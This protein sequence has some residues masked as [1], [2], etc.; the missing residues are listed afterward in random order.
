MI[1]NNGVNF[2]Q[3]FVAIDFIVH[4]FQILKH[5]RLHL[6]SPKFLSGIVSKNEMVKNDKECLKLVDEAIN[7]RLAPHQRSSPTQYSNPR[8]YGQVLYAGEQYIFLVAQ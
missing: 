3:W 8:K 1:N 2:Y 7:Y 4:L 6:C 5:V